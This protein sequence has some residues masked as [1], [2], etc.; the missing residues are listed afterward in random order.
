MDQGATR[1][2]L[3]LG[4]LGIGCTYAALG[5]LAA[6]AAGTDPVVAGDASAAF[7]ARVAYD[8]PAVVTG[9][10]S[11]GAAGE[12]VSLQYEPTGGSAFS[13]VATT[14]SG[15]G[16]SY[17][18][19]ARLERSGTL[20][21]SPGNATIASTTTA[22]DPSAQVSVGAGI[23][24]RP[25]VRDL[26]IGSPLVVRGLISTPARGRL[27]ALQQLHR[28][29]WVTVART[30]TDARGRYVVRFRPSDTGR[31]VLRV[32]FP[33]D[34]VNSAAGHRLPAIFIYRLAGASWYGP[35]G[36]T[37]CGESLGAGTL[38][39]ANKTLPCGTMV[40][41]RYGNRRVTVPVID[42]GPYVAGRDYDLTEATKYALGFGDVGDVWATA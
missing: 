29:G 10:L 12:T 34:S 11:N 33:G 26:L 3:A 23:A 28:R 41:L 30:R 39:V 36:T 31:A 38:G 27:V 18:L 24:A 8:A 13:T 25:R 20:S 5:P 17:K 7:P 19:T 16:G 42:R 37:A 35:G 9:R 1:A 15:A 14:T 6:H 4:A 40:T 2:M 22:T 32:R 21:V